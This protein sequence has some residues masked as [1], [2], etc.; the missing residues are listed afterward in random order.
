M[1][2]Y[3]WLWEKTNHFGNDYELIED[4]AWESHDSLQGGR[5]RG[6]GQIEIIG[7]ISCFSEAIVR[8]FLWIIYFLLKIIVHSIQ[9]V[10][11]MYIKVLFY[12]MKAVIFVQYII[13]FS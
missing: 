9:L 6:G 2:K 3:H 10:T 8:E 1:K 5:G 4:C 12:Y 11:A 7:K 13:S